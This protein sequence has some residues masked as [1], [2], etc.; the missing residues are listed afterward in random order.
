MVAGNIGHLNR[1]FAEALHGPI[2]FGI[3][4]HGGEVIM[5]DIGYRDRVVFTAMGDAVNIAARLQEMS[6]T[7]Q[8]EVVMSEEVR[9]T[10]AIDVDALPSAEVTLRGRA[11]P[12]RVRSAAKAETLAG[13]FETHVADADEHAAAPHPAA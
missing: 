7:L 9:A 12:M 1:A 6:K 3:G 2:Q 10:A 11:D 4:I 8:C 5:G 13:L